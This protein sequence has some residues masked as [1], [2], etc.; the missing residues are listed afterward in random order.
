MMRGG[1]L[2]ENIENKN[3]IMLEDAARI[4]RLDGENAVFEMKNGFLAL[5]ATKDGDEKTHDRVFLHRAFPHDLLWE[6]IS[7]TDEESHEIGLIY[8]VEDFDGE[9]KSLI[10]KEIERKYYSPVI[11]S[12]DSLKERYGFSY[13]KVTGEE[14]KSFAFTMQD[15]F[16]NIIHTG[17]DS[18]ILVDVDGNRY[19][20]KSISGFSR[21][22]YRKIELYL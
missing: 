18:L 4:F 20:V 12:I 6:Y 16:R 10:I 13:W 14:G 2:M 15:T 11:V 17:E 5:T 9:S 1:D 19:T 22:S 8:N 3:E 21:K 7:V